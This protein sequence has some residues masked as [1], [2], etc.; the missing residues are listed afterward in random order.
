[1][2]PDLN[3]LYYETWFACAFKSLPSDFFIITAHNPN[4]QT[5]SH[6]KNKELNNELTKHLD[7]LGLN[8]I[9]VAAGSKDR[10]HVETS[11]AVASDKNTGL[12]LCNKYEQDAIFWIKENRLNIV[13]RDGSVDDFI[14]LWSNRLLP[15]DEH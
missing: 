7:I 3:P 12:D 2:Y 13:K 14:D 15:T 5:V 8:Y 4:G 6:S 1:M 11:Y 10:C 9:E